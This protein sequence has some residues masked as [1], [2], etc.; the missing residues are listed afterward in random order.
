MNDLDRDA[1]MPDKRG[2]IARIQKVIAT[3]DPYAQERPV[4][5]TPPPQ[6]PQPQPPA[7]PS[8]VS[9]P[10]ELPPN[11][12]LDLSLLN[13]IAEITAKSAST[14]NQDSPK[15]K[16]LSKYQQPVQ[17]TSTDL[18]KS[19]P[20]LHEIL[21]AEMPLQCK[22]CALRFPDTEDGQSRLTVHLD[23]HFRRNMR[24]KERSKRVLARDW[25]GGEEDWRTERKT[26]MESDVKV[27][28]FDGAEASESELSSDEFVVSKDGEGFECAIC[29]ESISVAWSDDQEAWISKGAQEVESGIVH[30]SCVS[31]QRPKRQKKK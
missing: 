18:L 10:F 6:Q 2:I 26:N 8:S 3:G 29:H 12:Q 22:N 17:L 1:R 14:S 9:L 16:T 13:S 28:I 21:Y 5:R 30:V 7:S 23:S 25:F 4:A 15:K 19:I 11:F 27:N 31:N 24:L 20:R